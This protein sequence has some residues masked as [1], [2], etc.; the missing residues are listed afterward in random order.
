MQL[1]LPETLQP[2]LGS[3]YPRRPRILYLLRRRPDAAREAFEVAVGEWRQAWPHGVAAGALIARA[4]VAITEREEDVTSRFRPAGTEVVPIDG[5]VS[6]DLE[7]YAPTAAD[8]KVLFH[9]AHGCLDALDAVVDRA[10][11][12]ALAG[13]ASLPIPGYAPHSM[14][15]LLD[16]VP[17]LSRLQYN[18]WWVRHGDDHRRGFPAQA[19]YHQLHTDPAFNARAAEVAGTSTTDMCITDLMYIGDLDDA[20]ASVIDPNSTDGQAIGADI[21]S[22]VSVAKVTGSLFK[23][24]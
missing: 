5:Y 16:R 9:A 2:A 21:G 23:E 20:F 14:I 3:I 15:L 4:G 8:F 24:V 19:G 10:G 12:I 18:Q 11:T 13:V 7:S 17:S 1:S 6:L 22:H